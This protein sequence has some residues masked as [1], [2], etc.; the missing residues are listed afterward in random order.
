MNR[1]EK[2]RKSIILENEKWTR[3][4]K[5]A[6]A[7]ALLGIA[8]LSGGVGLHNEV[9]AAGAL[10]EIAITTGFTLYFAGKKKYIG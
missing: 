10:V 8:I 2:D 3:K 1:D 6:A 4:E 7:L 5:V 9:I